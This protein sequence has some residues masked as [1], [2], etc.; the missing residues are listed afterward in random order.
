MNTDDFSVSI[1]LQ[2]IVAPSPIISGNVT[3]DF[4]GTLFNIPG[5]STDIDSYFSFITGLTRDFY[6]EITGSNIENH[7]YII[8]FAGLNDTP[9]LNVSFNGLEGG[10]DTP[11]V[12]IYEMLPSSNNLF[13][14]PIPN[15][16]LFTFSN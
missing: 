9:I 16:F 11:I 2:Q 7:F 13:Y 15:E 6:T 5:N 10:Q 12:D 1:S 4:N 14:D 8:K 3:L